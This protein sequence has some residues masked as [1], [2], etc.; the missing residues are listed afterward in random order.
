MKKPREHEIVE[1]MFVTGMGERVVRWLYILALIFVALTHIDLLFLQVLLVPEVATGG[2]KLVLLLHYYGL[3]VYAL[4]LVFIIVKYLPASVVFHSYDLEW[5]RKLG[6]YARK[7]SP[8]PP[9]GRY[10]AGQK[11]NYLATVVLGI[12]YVLS[13]LVAQFPERF[14]ADL[15]RTSYSLHTFLLVAICGLTLIHI[16]LQYIVTSARRGEIWSGRVPKKFVQLHHSVWFQQALETPVSREEEERRR[17]ERLMVADKERIAKVMAKRKKLEGAQ[18]TAEEALEVEV[19]STPEVAE[20]AET[21]AEL[22]IEEVVEEVSVQ[23]EPQAREGETE[24]LIELA[25][26][27]EEEI[28]LEKDEETSESEKPH[29]EE[30]P[31]GEVSQ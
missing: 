5:L 13:G 30:H 12:F 9:A 29:E 31:E 14:S 16:Y 10:N 23:E 17:R 27:G 15:V 4:A 28:Q 2:E 26:T 25:T 11:I 8:V 22:E 1:M 20:G 24:E 21:P 6:G 7:Y 19:P 18:A 3:F